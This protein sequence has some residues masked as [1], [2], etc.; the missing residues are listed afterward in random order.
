MFSPMMIL[1]KRK[2]KKG[3][4]NK[5]QSNEGILK[6]SIILKEAADILIRE[7]ESSEM[8][9]MGRNAMNDYE[10]LRLKLLD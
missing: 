2:L 9:M 3:V 4:F 10:E 5:T 6:A 1:S 8:G 7:D